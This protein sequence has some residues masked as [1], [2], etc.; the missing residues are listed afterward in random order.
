MKKVIITFKAVLQE[1]R[2]MGMSHPGCCSQNGGCGKK[3]G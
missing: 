2:V 1:P 3:H